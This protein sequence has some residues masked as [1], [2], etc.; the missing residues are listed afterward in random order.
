MQQKSNAY[1]IIIVMRRTCLIITYLYYISAPAFHPE[2]WPL[3]SWLL[4][5]H[6][7][8]GLILPDFQI[9]LLVS[10]LCCEIIEFLL[11]IICFSLSHY[12]GV[13]QRECWSLFCSIVVTRH[14]EDSL[15]PVSMAFAPPRNMD[16]PKLQTKMSTWTPL[17][18]QLMNDKAS[19]MQTGQIHNRITELLR[20]EGTSG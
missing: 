15:S 1:S 10:W 9:I 12:N 18:H 3:L 13:A 5:V 17:N 4:W 20:L 7:M 8:K 14:Q 19:P 16:G 2:I 11:K 6:K